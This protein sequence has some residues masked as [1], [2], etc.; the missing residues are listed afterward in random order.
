MSMLAWGMADFKEGY[1]KA[2]QWEYA[3]DALRW[4]MDYMIKVLKFFCPNRVNT[5][6]LLI[7]DVLF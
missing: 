3:K 4:G 6:K 1:Q 2:G 5:W 7:A